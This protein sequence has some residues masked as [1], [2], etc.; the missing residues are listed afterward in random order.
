MIKRRDFLKRL[1]V[2]AVGLRVGPEAFS[3]ASSLDRSGEALPLRRLGK[4]G[5]AVTCLGLGGFHIGWIAEEKTAE[6]VIKASLEEGV[7]FFDTAESY[8]NGLSEERY[9]R[10]LTPNHR[11]EIFLTTKTSARDVAA[12]RRH[13]EGSLRRLKTDRIDLWQLHALA[14]PEDA[15]SRLDE[16]LLD[17]ALKAKAE[18]KVRHIGF[19]GHAS[20]YAHKHMLA[21]SK[22]SEAFEVCLMP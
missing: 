21:D 8:G 17:L 10:Y 2:A 16:G 12:A 5:E 20:P 11:E 9:G 4:T 13:L 3:G 14:S 18:G 1:A 22:A 19:T 7:R 15:A 6:A